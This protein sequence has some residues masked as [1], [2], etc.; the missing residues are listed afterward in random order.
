MGQT[1]SSYVKGV[2]SII[3]PDNILYTCSGLRFCRE[4]DGK[5]VKLLTSSGLYNAKIDSFGRDLVYRVSFFDGSK[6]DCIA[7]TVFTTTQGN[8]K[9]SEINIGDKVLKFIAKQVNSY[10][11]NILS[12]DEIKKSFEAGKL[13]S[14]KEKL[15][16]SFLSKKSLKCHNIIDDIIVNKYDL[17]N[18]IL[19][20]KSAQHGTISGSLQTLLI[21]QYLLKLNGTYMKIAENGANYMLVPD[22]SATQQVISIQVMQKMPVYRLFIN[23]ESESDH[24]LINN[25]AVKIELSD[26]DMELIKSPVSS[27]AKFS[28][29]LPKIQ[30]SRSTSEVDT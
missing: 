2:S 7:D 4:L 28:F 12:D 27:P 1:E 22:T 15:Q 21:L 17:H 19:G 24:L 30:F 13:Q 6:I 3:I 29:S 16:L 10:K 14:E 8:K 9:A 11:I 25:T 20:W 5:V 18:Y 26:K 23:I